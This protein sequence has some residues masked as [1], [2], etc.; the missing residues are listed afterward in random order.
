L[1]TSGCV[2]GG[3][4]TGAWYVA[5]VNAPATTGVDTLPSPAIVGIDY[6]P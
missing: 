2:A 6:V 4:L 3:A 5:S 1:N